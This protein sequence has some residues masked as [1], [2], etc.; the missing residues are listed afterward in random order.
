MSGLQASSPDTKSAVVIEHI[1]R[2]K[3]DFRETVKL[4]EFGATE[5]NDPAEIALVRKLDLYLMVSHLQ[6]RC[7]RSFANIV[8]SL[9]S[10]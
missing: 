10:G 5:K 8:P 2:V 4:D 6:S 7:P 1:D 3:K 9:R